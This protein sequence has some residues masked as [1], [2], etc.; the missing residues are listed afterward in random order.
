[1][2]A[3]ALPSAPIINIRGEQVALGPLM[4]AQLPLHTRWR[5]DLEVMRQLDYG[6]PWTL[7]QE[8]AR[9]DAL[10]A[11]AST[12]RFSI[13]TVA[14]WRPIGI[15][16]LDGI[17]QRNQT[18]EFSIVIGEPDA[19]NRGYGT[20]ATRLALDYAFTALGL[21]SVMLRVFAYNPAAQRAY[22]KAGFREFARRTEAQLMGG[23][24]W[25]VIYMECL[26]REFASPV[27]REVFVPDAPQEE[28]R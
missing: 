9:F 13:Y 18:S 5:N 21:H 3:D 19:R 14:D 1:M 23:R 24:Y 8:T 16:A 28:R 22:V 4:R 12:T 26:A 15:V 17:D 20:E 10:A 7:E 11:D 2:D 6:R 25:D 27:L